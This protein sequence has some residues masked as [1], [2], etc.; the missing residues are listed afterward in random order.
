MDSPT[1][2]R[3]LPSTK[4]MTPKWPPSLLSL[5]HGSGFSQMTTCS[6]EGPGRQ[7]SGEE[8]REGAKWISVDPG[9]PSHSHLRVCGVNIGQPWARTTQKSPET[10]EHSF[11]FSLLVQNVW[12]INLCVLSTYCV[13]RWGCSSEHNRHRE[14]EADR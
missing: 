11:F 4:G 9:S 5:S 10:T 14:G 13:P 6:S 7:S 8:S 12:L 2:E 3:H 1:H